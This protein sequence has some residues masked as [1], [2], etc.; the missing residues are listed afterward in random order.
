MGVSADS[1]SHFGNRASAW[2][3]VE[4][5]LVRV[6]LSK[7]DNYLVDNISGCRLS[8][9]GHAVNEKARCGIRAFEKQLRRESF[10]STG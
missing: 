10:L 1:A 7:I 5:A 2:G 9:L 6:R 8:Q 4:V 3:R